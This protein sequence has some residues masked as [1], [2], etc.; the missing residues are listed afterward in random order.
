MVCL[1]G[2]LAA[3]PSAS[4]QETTGRLA[5]QCA[6]TFVGGKYVFGGTTPAGFD[7]SGLVQYSYRRFGISLP[8]TAAEQYS[9]GRPVSYEQLQPGD[10]VFQAN[11]YKAGISHVGIYLGGGQWV[12]AKGRDYGITIEP[13]APFGPNHP[14]ARRIVGGAIGPSM[15]APPAPIRI[16]GEVTQADPAA[17]RAAV[18]VETVIAA[19][20]TPTT[21]RPAR[22]KVLVLRGRFA[23]FRLA[24]G[25]RVAAIGTDQGPGSPLTVQNLQVLSGGAPSMP[26]PGEGGGRVVRIVR[27]SAPLGTPPQPVAPMPAPAPVAPPAPTRVVLADFERD[28]EGWTVTGEAFGRLP[29]GALYGQGR[30]SG[31][32]GNFY[33]SSAHPAPRR[34]TVD[35]GRGRAV[36][37]DFPITGDRITF[38]IGGGRYDGRCCLNLVVDG[39]IVRT[40][41]GDNSDALRGEAWDVSGLKGKS[42]RLEVVDDVAMGPRGYI[43]IDRIEM[44]DSE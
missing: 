15:E 27:S 13:L 14:G 18:Q 10:L 11:T 44:R 12:Q 26:G 8:R 22:E 5:A 20:G 23:R 19:D 39:E 6:A 7:C 17:G 38:R 42:A 32:S 21:L 29:E 16:E 33:L 1:G 41:T 30:F 25:Q 35:S 3:M 43:L 31:W 9:C 37:K 36:S 4:A 40:A 2:L 28:F 34:F 24:I